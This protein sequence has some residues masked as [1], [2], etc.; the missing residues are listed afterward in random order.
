MSLSPDVVVEGVMRIRPSCAVQTMRPYRRRSSLRLTSSRRPACLVQRAGRV[1]RRS[2]GCHADVPV[3]RTRFVDLQRQDS[4]VVVSRSWPLRAWLES[5]VQVHRF[6]AVTQSSHNQCN[7][8]LFIR[9]YTCLS[10][11]SA[12]RSLIQYSQCWI[13]GGSRSA[14]G[15]P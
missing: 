9:A 3:S 2:R 8:V 14:L 6:A 15:L 12:P 5:A 13:L 11:S 7:F 1:S 4:A 10:G